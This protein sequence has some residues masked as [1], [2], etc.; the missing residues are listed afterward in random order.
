VKGLIALFLAAL[1]GLAVSGNNP[2]ITEDVINYVQTKSPK[3]NV[4]SLLASPDDSIDTALKVAELLFISN[5]KAMAH[6]AV[7]LL[8]YYE[9]THAIASLNLSL[10]YL[11]GVTVVANGKAERLLVDY[12]KAAEYSLMY[13]S[14]PLPSD[15]LYLIAFGILGEA[16]IKRE[17]YDD[18]ASLFLNNL[19]LVKADM[20]GRSAFNL[21]S[22]YRDGKGVEKGLKEAYHWYTV[23]ADKG[24]N[25]AIMERNFL[26]IE[27]EQLNAHNK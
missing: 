22:L 20:S 21:A 18:A 10:R 3:L 12:E 17:D 19:N 25:M 9:D 27:L 16:Y 7:E 11:E 26:A 15:E 23:A 24:L 1:S 6:K 2:I 13:L 14:N 8:K 5:N 4:Q